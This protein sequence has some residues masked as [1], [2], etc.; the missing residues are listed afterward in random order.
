MKTLTLTFSLAA[1]LVS[2]QALATPSFPAE[3]V[4]DLAITC[5]PPQPAGPD[6][7][8]PDC[9]LCHSSSTGGKPPTQPFGI[10]LVKFGLVP[11]DT[12]S[13]QT[14]L[15]AMDAAKTDSNNN[16]ISDID[17]LKACKNPNPSNGIGY[18]CS[19]GTAN[20]MLWVGLA[21][22]VGILATRRKKR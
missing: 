20:G 3:I 4:K 18:G 8:A 11:N 5:R 21:A 16:G 2:A 9:T 22:F 12:A 13:L 1:F 19:T 10:S 7:D 15:R 14:A 6:P 17:E